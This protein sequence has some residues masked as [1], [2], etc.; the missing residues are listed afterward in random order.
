MAEKSDMFDDV[1]TLSGMF[2]NFD[3]AKDV[4]EDMEAVMSQGSCFDHM[5]DVSPEM[6]ES[7]M[8]G[9]VDHI[10]EVHR[11]TE[12]IEHKKKDEY[13]AKYGSMI[14]QM[15]GRNETSEQA[16][17]EIGQLKQEL[18]EIK[19][20]MKKMIEVSVKTGA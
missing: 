16:L 20:L 2:G 3:N 14:S 18:G 7:F 11:R 4:T 15:T 12:E 6:I 17:D 1:K 9:K 13:N 10:N 8:R 19:D 5:S